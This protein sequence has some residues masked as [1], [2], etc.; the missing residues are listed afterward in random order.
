MTIQHNI[1]ADPDIHEPKGVATAASN[2]IY[3]ANGS[4]SGVWT[5]PA[6]LAGFS[7]ALDGHVF[8]ADGAGA[9]SWTYPLEGLDTA[10]AGEVFISD[11]ADSG[12]W[13]SPTD[14]PIADIYISGGTTA[15]TLAAASAYTILNPVGEWTEG[16]VHDLTTTVGNGHI[17]LTKAGN[18]FIS[19]WANF[20]TASIATG[21]FYNFK[22]ALDGVLSPR[23][24]SIAKF[25]NGADK[26]AVAASGLVTATAGQELSIYVAG[27]PT[28]SATDIT[29]T[30]AG[31]TALY[32]S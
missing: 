10:L 14:T 24:F 6:P 13:G 31:L 7:G 22:Y 21:S 1:I 2:S 4:G 17:N 25:T 9:G 3:V 8:I 28:A 18:Y 23:K 19:F 11:G 30:E 29:I 12:T 32:K 27:G 20:T 16:V 15:H 5:T 26:V